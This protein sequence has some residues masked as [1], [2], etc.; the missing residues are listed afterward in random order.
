MDVYL[1]SAFK[2]ML[3][4]DK[5]IVKQAAQSVKTT[6]YPTVIRTFTDFF[7]VKLT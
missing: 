3:Q 4:K 1:L 5:Q 2:E 7:A 6:D